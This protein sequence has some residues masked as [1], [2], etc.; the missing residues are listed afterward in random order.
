MCRLPGNP[1]LAALVCAGLAALACAGLELPGAAPLPE[2]PELWTAPAPPDDPELLSLEP[3]VLVAPVGEPVTLTLHGRAAERAEC[4]HARQGLLIEIASPASQAAV[5]VQCTAGVHAAFAQVTF[6]DAAELP[7]ADP[8]G[9]GVVLFKLRE[10]ADVP[11]DEI[12]RRDFGPASLER[13]LH[14]LGAWGMAAFPVDL[15]GRL[16][17]VGLRR[18]LAIDLPKRTNFYQAVALLRA[19]PA[20]HPESYLAEDAA[21]LRVGRR[22]SWPAKIVK[23]ERGPDPRVGPRPTQA[24]PV[25]VEEYS[26]RRA[27][28]AWPVRAVGAPGVWDDVRGRGIGI[29]IVD[30]GVDRRHRA[31]VGNVRAADDDDNGLP[32]D[33]HGANFAHLAIAHAYGPPGLALGLPGDVSDWSGAAQGRH[34]RDWGHGTPIA[35]LAAGYNPRGGHAG[36]APQAWILPVDVQE[37]LRLER[38]PDPRLRAPGRDLEPLREPVWARALGSVY[39]ATEGARVMTCAWPAGRAHQILYDA[40]RFAEDNCV[41]PVCAVEESPEGIPVERSWP[42]RWRDGSEIVDAWTRRTLPA[43]HPRPLEALLVVGDDATADLRPPAGGRRGWKLPASQ[44]GLAPNRTHDREAAFSGPGLTAGL[45]A[46]TAALVLEKRPD[47]TP[48]TLRGVLLEGAG[49]DRRVSV[50]GALE[51][52]DGQIVGDC[53][54]LGRPGYEAWQEDESIWERTKWRGS[55]QRAGGEPAELPGSHAPEVEEDA[56]DE[57]RE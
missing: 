41:L 11:P 48:Q 27:R 47:L 23:A 17:Y 46:G 43:L 53:S 31:L 39:A 7:T 6:T 21:F 10:P 9:G 3:R 15:E 13:L 20:L 32:G 45:V 55:L 25:S 57:P 33:T 51:A 49:P 56:S 36:V 28:P 22:K 16:D 35:A 2:L 40:L 18:W 19:D 34:A 29:A 37:N 54:G 38:S 5:D 30:T 52:L 12:G 1:R 44:P 8:Y 26:L 4:S 50:P 14:E 24:T 42:A